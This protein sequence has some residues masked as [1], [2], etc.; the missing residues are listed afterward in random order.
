MSCSIYRPDRLDLES[1]IDEFGLLQKLQFLLSN[2]GQFAAA[3]ITTLDHS[4]E[5]WKQLI[6]VFGWLD[7]AMQ[8]WMYPVLSVLLLASFID[9]LGFSRPVRARIAI[10]S[11]VTVMMYCVS[12]FAVFFLTETP[13]GADRIYGLQGRYFIVVLPVIAVTVSA[14]VNRSLDR[15]RSLVAI[16]S[17]LV[18]VVAMTEALWRV[19]WA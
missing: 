8:D 18:S 14:L 16:T 1:D 4:A 7:T 2:P 5:M 12:V 19:H 9:N 17:S 11:L 13:I 3:A 6:G 15:G 10:V